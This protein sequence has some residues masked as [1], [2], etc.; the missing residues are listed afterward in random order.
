MN[1]FKLNSTEDATGIGLPKKMLERLHINAGD[2]VFLL[3]T[4]EGYLLTGID[5]DVE[6]QLEIAREVMSEYRETLRVLAK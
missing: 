1:V 4:P 3:E 2:P 6:R 5:P